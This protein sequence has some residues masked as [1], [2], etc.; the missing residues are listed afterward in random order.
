MKN[1]VG[2]IVLAVIGIGA[3]LC[4][5]QLSRENA[6]LDEF[7]GFQ[8]DTNAEQRIEIAEQQGEIQPVK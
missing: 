8:Q 6:K 2:I 1:L 7:I 3:C 4:C 5:L